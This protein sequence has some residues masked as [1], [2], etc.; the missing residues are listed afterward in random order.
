MASGDA[1]HP[2]G[3]DRGDM[4]SDETIR[5]PNPGG[6][7]V[8]RA[9][10][11]L[12]RLVAFSDGVMAIAI[13]LLVLKIEVPDFDGEPSVG[14]LADAVV[15]LIP[16]I[17]TFVWSFLVVARFWVVH[18]RLF[19]GLARSNPPLTFLN[20]V[21]LLLIAL[22]PFPADLLGRFGPSLLSIALFAGLI[23]LT[24]LV[25]AWMDRYAYR[26]PGL[27]AAGIDPSAAEHDPFDQFVTP[28]V[29]VL[30][31]GVAVV[32]EDIAPY[33]W[34]LLFLRRPV[35]RLRVQHHDRRTTPSGR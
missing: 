8:G 9:D 35:R 32:Y 13:T 33:V 31:I 10:R 24:G 3:G 30:S 7:G 34:F 1:S 4:D 5:A 22:L 15:D 23:A 12:D 29:F 20:T 25:I 2:L 11:E 14:D 16:N 27:L 28:A 6:S 26:Q 17:I 18:R 21:F 19:S